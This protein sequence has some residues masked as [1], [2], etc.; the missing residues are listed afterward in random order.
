MNGAIITKIDRW[1]CKAD[2]CGLINNMYLEIWG[3][4]RKIR[5]IPCDNR[6]L[7]K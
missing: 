3:K 2:I 7:N 5:I 4:S 6:N 1:V